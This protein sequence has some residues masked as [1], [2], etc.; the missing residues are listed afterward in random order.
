MTVAEHGQGRVWLGQTM[1]RAGQ[2]RPWPLQA[3]AKHGQGRA[4]PGQSMTRG[5]HGQCTAWPGQSMARAG[6]VHQPENNA[7]PC[8]MQTGSRPHQRTAN[9]ASDEYTQTSA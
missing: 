4:G 8:T 1:A 3:R 2:G 6:P 7:L 5:K 9:A